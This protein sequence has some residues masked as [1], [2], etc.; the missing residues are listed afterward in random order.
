MAEFHLWKKEVLV[1]FAEKITEKARELEEENAQLKDDLRKM[2][3]AWR[4]LVAEKS[5][6]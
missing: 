2:H 6:T 5:S 3:E 4:K 1:D